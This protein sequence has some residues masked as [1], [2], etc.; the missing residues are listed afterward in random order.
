M[1]AHGFREFLEEMFEP[2]GG[3]TYRRMFGGLGIYRDGRMFALSA[4]DV[5]YFKADGETVPD[6]EAEGCGPFVYEGKNGR[7]A[8]M[9][10]WRVPER[11]YDEP[12]DFASWARKA[13]QAALR[14]SAVKSD[15]SRTKK[16]A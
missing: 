12:D 2:L 8:T 11:L 10:Y 1:P 6:F 3:V 13:F 16:R 7:T 14:A 9:S 15:R 5:L 4:D